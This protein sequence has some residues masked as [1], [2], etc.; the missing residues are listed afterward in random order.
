LIQSV[1]LRGLLA[2]LGHGL[3]TAILGVF[4]FHAAERHNRLRISWA[5]VGMYFVVVGLH[6]FWDFSDWLAIFVAGATLAGV[7]LSVLFD[8]VV[9]GAG[10]AILGVSWN[11]LV[12]VPRL[13]GRQMAGGYQ[14]VATSWQQPPATWPPQGPPPQGYRP[15]PI[16]PPAGA[17]QQPPNSG[18]SQQPAPPGYGQPGPPPRPGRG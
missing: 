12:R 3:W 17:W 9:G 18:Y 6:F 13:R 5:L 16:A 8:L 14:A 7:T 4:L 2:P 1:V 11:R 10:L 15:G